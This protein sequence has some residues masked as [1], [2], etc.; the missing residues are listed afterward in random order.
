MRWF[1][2]KN[3]VNSYL[4]HDFTSLNGGCIPCHVLQCFPFCSAYSVTGLDQKPT[5]LSHAG[6][7]DGAKL[8]K[9]SRE[10]NLTLLCGSNRRSPFK[11]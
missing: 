10:C 11:I 4:G 2:I 5:I 8:L 7:Y 3:S 9:H 6:P 1:Y